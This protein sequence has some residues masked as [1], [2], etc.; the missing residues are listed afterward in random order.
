[1]IVCQGVKKSFLN[2]TK[3]ITLEGIEPSLFYSTTTKPPGVDL[4][5]QQRESNPF[6]VLFQN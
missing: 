1:M 4:C 3:S 5:L 6:S 2:I